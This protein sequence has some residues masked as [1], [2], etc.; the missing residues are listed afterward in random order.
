MNILLTNDDGISSKGI[1]L[2]AE[3]LRKVPGHTIF[4][5]A[6][7]GE[8]SGVSH[9][10]TLNSNAIRLRFWGNN[11]WTCSGTPADCTVLA[12]S[13]VLPVKPDLVVSGINAGANLGTD[14][15][16][17]GTA[18]AARQAAIHGI[19]AIALSLVIGGINRLLLEDTVHWDK[20]VAFFRDHLEELVSLWKED[21]FIN[22][23]I[24]NTPDFSEVPEITF[25]SRRRYEDTLVGFDAPDG[26]RY[27]IVS[28]GLVNTEEEPGSDGD[29]ISRNR[30]SISPVF[31]H[32]VVRRDMCAGAPDHCTTAP[33]PGR[34]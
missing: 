33:R 25:P 11:T 20:A 26:S 18:G 21:T 7:D 31:I 16:Y 9:S 17:S 23:N 32:P 4:V 29:A 1:V 34:G 24:P 8:R 27:C 3:A 15:I 6:P 22:V 14:L 30:V 28:S 12:A 13:G 5:L 2:L 19:P 10:V